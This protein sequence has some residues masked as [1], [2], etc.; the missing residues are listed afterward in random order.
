MRKGEG[1]AI[2][3][4]ATRALIRR[5]AVR[6]CRFALRTAGSR[7]EFTGDWPVYEF[8][9]RKPV[10]LLARSDTEFCHDGGYHTRITFVRDAAGR[11]SRA[12]LNPERFVRTGIR[13]DITDGLAVRQLPSRSPCSSFIRVIGVRCFIV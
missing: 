7:I 6:S 11:T 2:D 5:P 8:E 12:V 1:D 4:S 10:A 13:K 9:S 3:I